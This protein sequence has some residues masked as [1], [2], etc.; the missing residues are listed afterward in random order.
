VDRFRQLAIETLQVGAHIVNLDTPA[1]NLS[2]T[3]VPENGRS[4]RA[5]P[6]II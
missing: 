1:W 4:L 3:T 6:A 5:R 2:P